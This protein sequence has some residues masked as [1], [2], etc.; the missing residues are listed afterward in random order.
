MPE[1][2]KKEGP[3]IFRRQDTASFLSNRKR[4]RP[5]AIWVDGE[6]RITMLIERRATDAGE[7]VKSLLLTHRENSGISKD[8]IENN[9]HIYS[10]SDR[11]IIKGP[12]KE[13]VDDVVS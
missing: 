8:L 2:A 9:I 10:G 6:M 7:F 13:A 1:Y 11:K 5:I 12:A 4:K 3:E